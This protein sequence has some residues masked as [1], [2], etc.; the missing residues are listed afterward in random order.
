[1]DI[2]AQD[3]HQASGIE[4]DGWGPRQERRRGGGGRRSNLIRG[5]GMLYSKDLGD[6]DD[7]H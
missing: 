1:M 5:G 7:G 6:N 2:A 3:A 4:K